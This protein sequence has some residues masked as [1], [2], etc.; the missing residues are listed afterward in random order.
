MS[1][2][3]GVISWVDTRME[4]V[5][6][7][8]F[9]RRHLWMSHYIQMSKYILC[10][11][12]ISGLIQCKL[13]RDKGTVWNSRWIE[14]KRKIVMMSEINGVNSPEKQFHLFR[15]LSELKQE[16]K[17]GYI[18]TEFIVPHGTKT[19]ELGLYFISIQMILCYFLSDYK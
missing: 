14:K 15:S 1:D 16:S 4:G 8:K 3:L 5:G 6:N 10:F 9:W 11:I 19:I 12:L 17:G 2:F 13:D 7:R 18:D